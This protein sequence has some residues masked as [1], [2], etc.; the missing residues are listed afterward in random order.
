[1]FVKIGIH[2]TELILFL[3]LSLSYGY[4]YQSTHHNEAARFD[5]MR[6]IVQDHVLEINKYWWNTADVIHYPTNGANQIYPNKAPGMTLV[7]VVPFAVIS[8][9]LSGLYRL[10]LVNGA[11]WHVVTYLTT[12]F[13]VSLLSALA[14][15]A[16]YR[17]LRQMKADPY[18]SILAVTGIWLGTLAFPYSTLFFSHQFVA[19]LLAIAFVLLFQLRSSDGMSARGQ[20]WRTFGAGSLISLSVAAEYPTALLAIALSTYALCIIL[21]L[22][23]TPR[24][25]LMLGL[26]G[27]GGTLLGAVLLIGYNVAAFGK[28][29]YIPYESY[30]TAGASFSGTYG[31]GWLG[32]QP[33]G[34][35]Q[36]IH[37]LAAVTVY[38]KI[39]ML[40]LG[41]QHWRIYA[42]N[43]VLWL[44]VPG[45]AIM[46]RRRD[47]RPEGIL[48]AAMTAAYLLF[49]THYGGSEYDWSGASY[50]GSR[51]L[52]PLLPFLAWPLCLSIGIRVLRFAFYPLFGISLFYMLIL[53]ATEP[54]VGIPYE[55]PAR[56]LLAPDYL[57]A[58]FAQNTDGLFAGQRDLAKQS[59]AFN[60]GQ[61]TGLPPQ[62]Q[63][64]PLLGWWLLSGT[65]L[66]GSI[67]Q[68]STTAE[69][70]P[71]HDE[72]ANQKQKRTLIVR[73]STLV[74]FL[75]AIGLPP[76]VHHA[77]VAAR[78]PQ[79]GLRGKYFR[80][81]NWE[82]PAVEEAVDAEVNFDWTR[83][84]PLP[85]P[86][87][88]DW[89]GQ[90]TIKQ[91]GRYEFALIA[92][93]GALLEIDG[94]V[95]VDVS[96]GPIL[97]KKSGSIELSPGRH[98][99]RVR[100]F[101]ALFGGLVKLW[102]TP[103]G[104]SEEIVPSEVLVPAPASVGRSPSR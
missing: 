26:S 14:A 56:D 4:F 48:V 31:H 40:Y 50:V 83:S 54:R 80:N 6:A 75:I 81:A 35:G 96:R 92:D 85:P 27:F 77:A 57:R 1:L 41:I 20:L 103:P 19:A 7:S 79:Q 47:S 68:K 55:N 70:P 15:V 12:L 10:G 36:F 90:I 86:F 88:I 9:V 72:I 21:R 74:A 16:I 67:T 51:H 66:L 18:L 65:M 84:L 78:N 43:P 101:N 63:L 95:V 17:V 87:S 76:A 37:A 46:I 104:Q 33:Q 39:G 102:W 52:I 32:L 91:N 49:I 89:T 29:L 30:A 2:R 69:T 93:D 11:Y 24:Q 71:A 22:D 60:L 25:R 82:E 99:I 98:E 44:C 58:R 45:L 5:Q 64:W 13:G 42:C 28:P 8:A 94:R 38:P 34:V 61:L 59:A 23:R 73:S 53:T 100:Y 97:Q 3:L 62:H